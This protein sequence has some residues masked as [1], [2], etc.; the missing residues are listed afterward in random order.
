MQ[1]IRLHSTLPELE[2]GGER[3]PQAGHV[4]LK[5]KELRSSLTEDEGF[6]T[7]GDQTA[8]LPNFSLT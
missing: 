6:L 3:A 8:S 2:S 5:V 7:S 4:R 1:T